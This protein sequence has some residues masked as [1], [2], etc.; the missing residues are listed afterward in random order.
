VCE[1]W[2]SLFLEII[3]RNAYMYLPLYIQLISYG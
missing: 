2:E 3:F 1:V